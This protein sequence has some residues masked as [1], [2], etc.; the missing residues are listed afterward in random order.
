MKQ[1]WNCLASTKTDIKTQNTSSSVVSTS[2]QI[3]LTPHNFL[4]TWKHE[5][6]TCQEKYNYLCEVGGAS[7]GKIFKN[8]ISMGLLGEF[9]DV[10]HQSHQKEDAESILDIL[11]HLSTTKRFNLSLDFLSSKEKGFAQDLFKDLDNQDSMNSKDKFQQLLNIY[12][13]KL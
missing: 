7:L 1:P 12:K 9:V 11:W 3:Q 2:T 4:K 6:K 13:I 10:L 8:E 5:L